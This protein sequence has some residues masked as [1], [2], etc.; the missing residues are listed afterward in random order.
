VG[1]EVGAR[2]RLRGAMPCR[3]SDGSERA[4]LLERVEILS[5]E[6]EFANRRLA[7]LG[8]ASGPASKE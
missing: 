2:L 4:M 6:L 5:R 7:E 8:E 3:P 1:T